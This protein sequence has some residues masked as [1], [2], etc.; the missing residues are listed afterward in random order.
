VRYTTQKK[1]P[2]RNSKEDEEGQD[3]ATRTGKLRRIPQT[4]GTDR[5][6]WH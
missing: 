3:K 1:K 5:G 4:V 2:G 6:V